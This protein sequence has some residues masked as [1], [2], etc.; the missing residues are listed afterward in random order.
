MVAGKKKRRVDINIRRA[1]GNR[2]TILELEKYANLE[3]EKG[4]LIPSDAVD[5][6][7]DPEKKR[8]ATTGTVS[9]VVTVKNIGDLI[10]YF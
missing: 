1:T 9:N 2:N 4:G 7:R 8:K 6:N 10:N 3:I 5:V